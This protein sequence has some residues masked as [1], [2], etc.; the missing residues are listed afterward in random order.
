MVPD[1]SVSTSSESHP[2]YLPE[3]DGLRGIAILLVLWYHAPFLFRS[4][5]FPLNRLRGRC[6]A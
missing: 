1:Q 6:S 2:A 3:V 4:P 5:S